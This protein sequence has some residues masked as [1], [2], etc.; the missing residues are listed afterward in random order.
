M[1]LTGMLL[2]LE[3]RQRLVF[4]LGGLFGIPSSSGAEILDISEANFRA[5]LSRA[6]KKLTNFMEERCGL[7]NSENPCRCESHVK[8]LISAGW[9]DPEDLRLTRESLKKLSS[10]AEE[11]AMAIDGEIGSVLKQFQDS[12]FY[13]GPGHDIAHSGDDTK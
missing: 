4:I 2:C 9:I 10:I 11:R 3:R 13:K 1:C 12:S 8:K 7:V 5:I 6:R